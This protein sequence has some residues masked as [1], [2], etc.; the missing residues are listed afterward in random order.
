MQFLTN[1]EY[2]IILAAGPKTE[3]LLKSPRPKVTTE[4]G[5]PGKLLASSCGLT[6]KIIKCLRN[7]EPTTWNYIW[8]GSPRG[9]PSPGTSGLP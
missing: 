6:E 8:E 1:S 4:A 3:D 2:W 5:E 7:L 9:C